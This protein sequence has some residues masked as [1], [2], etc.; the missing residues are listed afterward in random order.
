[1]HARQVLGILK[2]AV[3]HT[4]WKGNCLSRSIVL[5]GLLQRKGISSELCIGVRNKPKFR[6]HAWVE[7]RETPLNAGSNVYRNYQRVDDFSFLGNTAFL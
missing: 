4:L 7:H 3:K 1:M 5:L 2:T 6:A